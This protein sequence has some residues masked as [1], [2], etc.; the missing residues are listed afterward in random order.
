MFHFTGNVKFSINIF[1]GSGNFEICEGDS[2]AVTGHISILNDT[3]LDQLEAEL[4]VLNIDEN[5][6]SL[7]S[8]DI[9]KDL[10]LRGYDYKGMFRGIKESDNKGDT[11]NYFFL[12]N[13]FMYFCI[14]RYT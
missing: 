11:I 7:K 8:E 14:F 5:T 12:Q 2:V 1:E 6:I 10:G 9:Y 4:P 13:V 3:D